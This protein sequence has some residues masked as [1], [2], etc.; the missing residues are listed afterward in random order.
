MCAEKVERFCSMDCASPMSVK[1]PVKMGRR[2]DSAGMGT[3]AW[4]MTESRP[5]V[6]SATDL[7]PVLGPLMIIWRWPA[8]S[9]TVMGMMRAGFSAQAE[10]EQRMACGDDFES[11][12]GLSICGWDTSAGIRGSLHFA[13]LRSR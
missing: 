11:G 1:M 5:T 10:L 12:V 4:A 8:G 6:L 3:P 13:S 9:A 2:A 7:P